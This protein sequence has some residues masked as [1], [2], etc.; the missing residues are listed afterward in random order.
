MD[1]A[2]PTE[3]SSESE[4]VHDLPPW[5]RVYKDGKIE[6][7][8]GCGVCAPGLDSQ[9]DVLSKDVVIVQET[10]VSARLHRPNV[11]PKGQ[12]LPL[13]L[14]FHGGA[15]L[16][17]SPWDPTYH[18]CVNKLVAEAKVVLVS[19]DYRKA[20]EHPLPVAFDDSW[21]V[22]KWAALHTSSGA[23]SEP[24][25][26]DNVDFNR[27]FLA[28]D[29]A[30]ASIAYQLV[31]RN[32]TEKLMMKLAGIILINP[33]FWGNEPIGAE[34][35]NPFLK[36]L[37]DKWWAFV[38]PSDKG[39]DDPLVNPL[40][41][42]APPLEQLECAKILVSVSEKDILRDRGVLF[43][44]SL[45]KSEWKGKAELIDVKGE[46]HV[47]HIFNPDCENAIYLFKGLAAFINA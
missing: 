13:V 11:I 19:V 31:I 29:S 37:V 23:G 27:V 5:L 6:R 15:Y 47:F 44:E 40:A 2:F 32:K 43:Y 17:S 24:W 42:G 16:I 9:T 46:D 34:V 1:K 7:L 21:D 41:A 28:G 8:S 30:G 33:Y 39:N 22:L 12:K 36:A 45:K 3:V 4:V 18:N 25:L 35:T 20:P 10:G 26:L 38:C 14:Y